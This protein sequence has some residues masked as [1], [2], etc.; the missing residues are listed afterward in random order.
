VTNIKITIFNKIFQRVGFIGDPVS[1]TAT[2]RHNGQSTAT[3]EV[4]ADHERIGHLLTPGC[5]LVIE[6]NPGIYLSGPIMGRSG[7]G[8]PGGTVTLTVEDDW[9]LLT[10]ILGW[11]APTQLVTNQ[12][13][14]T[15]YDTKT[16]PAETVLKWFAGRNITRLALPITVAPD[17]GRG[18]TMTGSL[19]MHRLADR[20]LPAIDQASIGVTVRQSGTG[21]VVDCY[22]PTVRARE[23]TPSSGVVRSWSWQQSGPAATR[24]VVGGQ[25]E[26]TAREFRRRIATS[27]ETE[28]ADIVEGFVDARDTNVAAELDARGDAALLEGAPKTGLSMDLAETGSFRYGVAVNVGD[29]VTT[30]LVPGAPPITDILREVS[31]TWTADEGLIITP[32]V[33]E[34]TDDPNQTF[35]R[36]VSS[37]ARAVRNINSRS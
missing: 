21:L 7:T 10:R 30:R 8:N 25:G 1:V 5:R 17:L 12:G 24:V 37:V 33:G 13:A 11:P 2:I 18:A 22:A 35:A 26:G 6:R 9:R 34:R 32:V 15:A 27:V 23:I 29:Q 16:G 20:L 28:W 4:S 36:A 19:R 14:A 3:V 31:L